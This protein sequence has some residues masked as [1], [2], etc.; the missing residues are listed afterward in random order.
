MRRITGLVLTLGLLTLGLSMNSY[1]AGNHAKTRKVS[2]KLAAISSF[3]AECSPPR[4]FSLSYKTRSSRHVEFLKQR[5]QIKNG[6][7]S[8]EKLVRDNNTD[9]L[10]RVTFYGRKVSVTEVAV[11]EPS[12]AS[13]QFSFKN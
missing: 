3:G 1:A 12:K 9:H 13:C 11:Q 10:V 4:N 8:L 7:G 5:V 2:M 6:T